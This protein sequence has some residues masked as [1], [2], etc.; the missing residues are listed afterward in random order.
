[1]RCKVEK[2]AFS[3]LIGWSVDRSTGWTK[4]CSIGRLAGWLVKIKG[5]LHA[6]LQ[7]YMYIYIYTFVYL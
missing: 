5:L 2:Y 7:S 1:M 3:W 6:T 4:A